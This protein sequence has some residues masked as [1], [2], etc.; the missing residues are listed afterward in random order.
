M[1]PEVAFDGRVFTFTGTSTKATRKQI[2]DQITG[3][4]AEFS[5][6]VTSQTHYLVVGAGA[7]PCW[8]F[9]CYGRKV[10]KAIEVR[11]SGGAILIVH[12]SD[13]WDAV[14]DNK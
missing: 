7:N 3:L 11:K 12:E 4:G 14:E 9:S 8:A 1:C 10:E 13:F 5:P 2:V 6:N